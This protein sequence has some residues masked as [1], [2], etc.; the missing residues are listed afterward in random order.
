MPD[1][2]NHSLKR[3]VVLILMMLIF[4]LPHSATLLTFALVL[5]AL[6]RKCYF[7]DGTI[8]T[9]R[10]SDYVPCG[11]ENGP[12]S[13]CCEPGEGCS[14]TGLCF[15]HAG[16]MYR[17]ACTDKTWSAPACAQKCTSGKLYIL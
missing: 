13:A 5:P 1:H 2:H 17:G 14:T 16:Y 3:M 8:P 15:G 9:G 6:A 7:P 12:H 10:H 11:P 4:D